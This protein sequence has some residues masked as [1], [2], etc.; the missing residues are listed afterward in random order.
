VQRGSGPD[1]PM[2][3]STP[4]LRRCGGVRTG[5]RATCGENNETAAELTC[6]GSRPNYGEDA[7]RIGAIGL[8]VNPGLGAELWRG[9]AGAVARQ[10][11][12]AAM[13]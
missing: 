9:L 10:G 13:A 11:D 5:Q 12:V 7:A 8:R 4:V 1:D 2:G 6:V 3:R